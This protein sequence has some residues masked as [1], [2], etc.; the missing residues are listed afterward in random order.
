[1]VNTALLNA[2]LASFVKNKDAFET[3]RFSRRIM[4]YEMS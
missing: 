4:I 1:M 2:I 3:P